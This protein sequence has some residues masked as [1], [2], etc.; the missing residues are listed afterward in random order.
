MLSLKQIPKLE[1]E[2]D[3][4]FISVNSLNSDVFTLSISYTSKYIF[5]SINGPK[6]CHLSLMC[7]NVSYLSSAETEDNVINI[8]TMIDYSRVVFN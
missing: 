1:T 3:L 8:S 2:L 6:T 4:F 7:I 5:S